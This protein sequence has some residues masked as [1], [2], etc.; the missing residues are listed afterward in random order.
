[1]PSSVGRRN[2][3]ENILR[4]GGESGIFQSFRRHMAIVS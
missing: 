1:M 2:E 4:A 3:W